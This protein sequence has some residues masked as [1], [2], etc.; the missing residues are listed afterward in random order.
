MPRKTSLVAA[1]LVAACSSEPG[2]KPDTRPDLARTDASADLR[3]DIASKPEALSPDVPQG[4]RVAAI[5]YGNGDFASVAG[6]TDNLCGIKHYVGEAAKS[7]AQLVLTPEYAFQKEID[8]LIVSEVD[9]A[10]SIGDNLA[11]DAK[12]KIGSLI[13]AQAQLAVDNKITLVFEWPTK[14]GGG[15]VH[16][17]AIAVDPTGKVIARHYK[18]QL[19]GAETKHFVPGTSIEESIFTSTAGKAGI[20]LGADVHC[21]NANMTVTNECTASALDMT[22]KFFA[23]PPTIVLFTTQW[24]VANTGA[25]GVHNVAQ[26]M[27]KDRSAWVLCSNTTAL[28]GRGGGI[29]KPDGTAI[30]AITPDKPA[31]VYATIPIK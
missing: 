23:Q 25:W 3:R 7:G 26:K 13:K 2:S 1:L 29:W 21:V 27:A 14:D 5:Q 22:T 8:A 16:E 17:T 12:W 19:Y 6:C 10:P 24:T 20:L 18:F 9:P 4:Y 28:P 30:E 15:A 31:I 11:S